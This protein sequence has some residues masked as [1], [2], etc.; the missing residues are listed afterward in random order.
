M[1]KERFALLDVSERKRKM[2]YGTF[3][4]DEYCEAV[5]ALDAKLIG[6]YVFN[7][8]ITIH[9]CEVTPSYETML[10]GYEIVPNTWEQEKTDEMNELEMKILGE[11]SENQFNYMHIKMVEKIGYHLLKDREEETIEELEESYQANPWDYIFH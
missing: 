5:K 11:A 1:V 2:E 7:P 8:S 10:V 4:K 9:C 6:T 3:R